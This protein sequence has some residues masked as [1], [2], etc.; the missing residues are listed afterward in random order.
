MI[1]NIKQILP[2]I[3]YGGTD[4]AVTTF[5][6]MAGAYGAGLDPRIVLI[7]GVA[8]LLSDGF[9]MASA[10]YLSEESRDKNLPSK[11]AALYLSVT[12][13]FS[14]VLVGSIPIIPFVFAYIFDTRIDNMFASSMLLTITCF[15]SIGLLRGYILKKNMLYLAGQTLLVGSVSASIAYLVGDFLSKLV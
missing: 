11:R 9:S 14:F 6:V 15:I 10:D 2:A 1:I 12:T 3:V 4:G 7:L 5:S 13:F 8:N